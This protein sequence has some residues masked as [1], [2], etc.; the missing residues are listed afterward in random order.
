MAKKRTPIVYC[1]NCNG[2]C[3]VND[4]SGC[5]CEAGWH[6]RNGE[7]CRIDG[8]VIPGPHFCTDCGAKNERRGHQSCQYP[9]NG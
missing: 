4:D 1:N 2:S 5:A 7:S 9:S 8:T 6:T 3:H